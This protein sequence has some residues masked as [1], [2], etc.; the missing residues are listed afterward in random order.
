MSPEETAPL[1]AV[2]RLYQ[3]LVAEYRARYEQ[4]ELRAAKDLLLVAL[5]RMHAHGGAQWQV[6]LDEYRDAAAQ[7]SDRLERIIES[8]RGRSSGR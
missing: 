6:L 8:N 4:P 7:D 3:E 5:A 1:E 2:E